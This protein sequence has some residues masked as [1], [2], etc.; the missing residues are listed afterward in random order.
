MVDIARRKLTG[1]LLVSL[2]GNVA[3]SYVSAAPR[4]ENFS[5]DDVF[6]SVGLFKTK[7]SLII[8]FN[9]LYE[10]YVKEFA[11]FSEG[12]LQE[13]GIQLDAK[14]EV[15]QRIM[16]NDFSEAH[17]RSMIS[18]ERYDKETVLRFLASYYKSFGIDVFQTH[19]GNSD[20][21]SVALAGNSP[22]TVYLLTPW[23]AYAIDSVRLDLNQRILA[24]GNI[25]VTTIKTEA[26]VLL[27]EKNIELDSPVKKSP[28]LDY[29]LFSIPIQHAVPTFPNKFSE[30]HLAL[31]EGIYVVGA[32]LGLNVKMV[33]QG[34][35]SI[36]N[37]DD[38]GKFIAGHRF[39]DRENLFGLNA[40][41]KPGDSG[42]IVI[43]KKRDLVGII[44]GVV[45]LLPGI[46]MAV[47]ISPIAAN[48]SD[49]VSPSCRMRA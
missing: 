13:T 4:R 11:E 26:K 19:N 31:G 29:T 41:L 18:P 22:N 36:V 20:S 16:E 42:G 39:L 35:V 15:I 24:N 27:G 30:R 25:P 28:W 38:I 40:Y 34:V 49:Y 48:I 3:P 46:G 8:D 44:C 23:H 21:S 9:R 37:P 43:D 10:Q 7:L 5:I 45:S 17:K 32:P 6:R 12:R 14:T 1:G 47:K 2:L 33:R